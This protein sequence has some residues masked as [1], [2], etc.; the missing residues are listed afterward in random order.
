MIL[1]AI[2][3]RRP[4]LREYVLLTKPGI[5]LGNL[6]SFAGGFLLAA[7]G[8]VD[9][10]LLGATALGIALVMAC[11]CVCNNLIDRDIDSRMSRTRRRSLVTGV[12][13]PLAAGVF[14]AVLGGFG[15]ALLAAA[16]GLLVLAVVLAGFLNYVVLY[17]LYGK[18]HSVHGT[19][20]GSF[21]GATAP[22]A[23][24][25]A[26][27]GRFDAL[28]LLLLLIFCLWQMP[29]A[30]AIAIARLRDYAD[31]DI[32][33]LPVRHGIARTKRQ[34]RGFIGAFVVVALA[35]PLLHYVGWGYGVAMAAMGAGWLRVAGNGRPGVDD[36]IWARGVFGFSLLVVLV[37]SV[38]LA[39]DYVPP[40]TAVALH[41]L[42][43]S[44]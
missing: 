4:L 12:V 31:A 18:R 6:V 1:A 38:M 26:V 35:L 32:P 41:E 9:W 36:R 37:L 43:P 34:I 24:Y 33:V 8:R 7:R 40:A 21:A 39:I 28:A 10:L 25:C 15:F 19:L 23:G 11:A 42:V 20:V 30:Y 3:S 22:V 5:I 14:A 27:S 13:S 2:A 44:G 17:S 29:H 16:S